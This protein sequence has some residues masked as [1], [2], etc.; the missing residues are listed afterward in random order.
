MKLE[1]VVYAV[2]GVLFGLIVGW[3]IGSEQAQLLPRPRA[4]QQEA[5]AQQPAPAAAPESPAPARAVLDETKVRALETVAEK[6]P[7]NAVARAQLGD[8]YYDAGKYPEAIR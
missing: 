4:P 1:S 6:D 7:K 5:A 8:A 3:I 2:S